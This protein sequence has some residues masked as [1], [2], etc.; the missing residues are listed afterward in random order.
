M[1]FAVAVSS[2]FFKYVGQ[3]G[4]DFVPTLNHPFVFITV[5]LEPLV[6][7]LELMFLPFRCL[8]E[9][10]HLLLQNL[11]MCCQDTEPLVAVTIR[12]TIILPGPLLSLLGTAHQKLFIIIVIRRCLKINYTPIEKEEKEA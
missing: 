9:H 4:L 2:D 5:L 1:D 3:R 7:I 12:F 10:F 8:R 11:D 6:R